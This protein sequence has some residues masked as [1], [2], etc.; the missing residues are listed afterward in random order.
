MKTHLRVLQRLVVVVAVFMVLVMMVPVRTLFGAVTTTFTVNDPG[1]AGDANPGDGVCSTPLRKCTLRAAIQQNNASGG[2]TTISVPAMTIVLTS[3]TELL[4]TAPVTINGA[5]EGQTIID[6]NNATRVLNFYFSSGTHTVSGLT[7]RNANCGTGCADSPHPGYSSRAGGGGIFNESLGLTLHHVSITNSRSTQGG[8]LLNEYDSGPNFV[9]S[10]TLNSVSLTSCTA[11][12]TALGEGGGGMLNG[13]SLTA[14]GLTVN[15]NTA[16]Q[17]GGWLNNGQYGKITVS[18]F[19]INNNVAAYGG[20][21]NNETN[22]TVNLSSGTISGNLSKYSGTVVG[23]GGIY[24]NDG[25]MTLTDVTVSNNTANSYGG[26]GGGIYNFNVMN[27]YRVTLSGNKATYGAAL[28]SGNVVGSPSS[29]SLTNVT[30]SGN[31]A[32]SLGFGGG[33]TDIGTGGALFAYPGGQ[34]SMTNVT[35]GRN[36]AGR[37]GAID[38]LELGSSTV[39]TLKNTILD[40]NTATISSPECR[41]P[42][43]S[44]GYNLLDDPSGCSFAPTT[45]DLVGVHA[46]LGALGSNGGPTQTMALP[47]GSRAIDAGTNTGCPPTDQRNVP[48]P[49]NGRCDMGDYEYVPGSF[50]PSIWLP[51]LLAR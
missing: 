19:S 30:I 28:A 40:G 49:Q 29:M 10:I 51:L 17:G 45:G 11:T 43:T 23:G 24:N 31:T 18:N 39:I 3:N 32:T 8:C 44:A 25:A 41:G 21:I 22:L 4:V 16:Y 46:G 37:G 48:R 5:G 12:S 14:S 38:N 42:L 1:D 33:T 26:Y 27:L 7:I 20:G 9:P 36:T 35:I 6:G 50:K 15:G 34:V 2:G 13:G 47:L